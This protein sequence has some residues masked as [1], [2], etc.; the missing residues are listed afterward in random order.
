MSPFGVVIT[1]LGSRNVSVPRAPTPDLP[2]CR[3]TFPSGLNFVTVCPLPL[4]SGNFASSASL[5]ARPS[6][7]Q[8]LPSRSTWMPCGK[9]NWPRPKL[10]STLPVLRSNFRIGSTLEPAQ[11]FA[12]HRS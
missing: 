7:I 11:L 2:N 3:S 10:A 6:V 1:S 4:A 12:P 8:T 5:A 9:M